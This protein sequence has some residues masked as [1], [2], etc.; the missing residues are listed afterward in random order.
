MNKTK[1]MIIFIILLFMAG[2]CNALKPTRNIKIPPYI[3]EYYHYDNPE[4]PTRDEK[5][6]EG[7]Y[8]HTWDN[9]F[10]MDFR[11][12]RVEERSGA[13]FYRLLY[14]AANPLQEKIRLLDQNIE[15]V[16]SDTAVSIEQLKCWNWQKV[17]YPCNVVT[18]DP[19][20][21]RLKEIRFGFSVDEGYARGLK[22]HVSGLSFDKDLVSIDFFAKKPKD[23]L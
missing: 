21:E 20:G 1:F 15:L 4:K 18:I 3:V 11:I 7:W 17:S 2:C 9:G 5:K 10:Q 14:R 23:S 6:S 19:E 16:D 13:Y 8:E 12:A 22:V